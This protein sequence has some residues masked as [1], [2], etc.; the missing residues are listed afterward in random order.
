M[1]FEWR[2]NSSAPFPLSADE[3]K[4]TDLTM[5]QAAP[6]TGRVRGRVTNSVDGSPVADAI[7]KLRSQSGD[8]ISHTQTNPA[9]N[10][11]IESI[12]PGTYTLNVTLQGFL[13]SSGQTF[14]IQGG[15]TLDIDVSITPDTQ[16]RNTIYGTVTDLA[17]GQ[18]L[19]GVQV[20]L[21]P[22][23]TTTANDTVAVSNGEGE[24]LIE[25]IPDSTQN[26]LAEIHGYYVSSFIPVTISGDTILQADISLQRYVVPNST[27][28]G[29]ITDQ[30]GQPLANICVGLYLINPQNIEILQQV[31]FTDANGFYIFGRAAAGT[32]V[33]KAKSEKETTNLIEEEPFS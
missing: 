29:F 10:Y 20:V 3:E 17:T 4:R 18:P 32:Y 19:D 27:V 7:V 26:L 16:P 1:T 22:D 31:T 30:N 15:Q 11:I 24:Y 33:V 2:K 28:N 21:K 8:P 23:I 6:Q 13:I 5:T 12:S 25:K 9:G 14:S